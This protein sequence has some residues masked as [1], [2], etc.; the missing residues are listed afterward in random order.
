MHESAARASSLYEPTM[1]DIISDSGASDSDSDD[2]ASYLLVTA[3]VS[4]NQW[5]LTAG[6]KRL[7][8]KKVCYAKICVNHVR[9]SREERKGVC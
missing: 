5:N 4:R 7:R 2:Y 6:E 3:L 1:A 9:V 8:K